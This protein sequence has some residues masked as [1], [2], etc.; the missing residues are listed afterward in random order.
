MD[1]VHFFPSRLASE[2]WT[3]STFHFQNFQNSGIPRNS[4]EFHGIPRKSN[5]LRYYAGIPE[6]LEFLQNSTRNPIRKSMHF[7]TR[8]PGVASHDSVRKVDS[9]HFSDIAWRISNFRNTE[10]AWGC[11]LHDSA[12]REGKKWTPR[13][14]R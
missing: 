9:V 11:A 14:P 5:P 1:T 10:I 6:F 13:F 12:T 3:V 4:A 8:K 7:P 2:K